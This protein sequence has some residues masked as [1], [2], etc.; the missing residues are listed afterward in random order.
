MIELRILVKKQ[1]VHKL[2]FPAIIGLCQ[3]SPPPMHK[4]EIETEVLQW[5]ERTIE[6]QITEWEDVEKVHENKINRR[7]TKRK[8]PIEKILALVKSQTALANQ[9]GGSRLGAALRKLHELIEKEFKKD[10]FK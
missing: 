9:I 2:D 6:N 1:T 7:A 8:S 10:N 5:R 4:K 3:D